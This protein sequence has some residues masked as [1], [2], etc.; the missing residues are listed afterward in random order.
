LNTPDARDLPPNEPDMM[1]IDP[2]QFPFV[3]TVD[4]NGEVFMGVNY[5]ALHATAILATS[6]RILAERDLDEFHECIVHGCVNH[7]HPD[8]EEPGG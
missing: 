2:E 4:K 3:M 7:V 5:C 1:L 6:L 8:N